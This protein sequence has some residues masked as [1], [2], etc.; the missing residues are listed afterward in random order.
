M[1]AALAPWRVAAFTASFAGLVALLASAAGVAAVLAG[2]LAFTYVACDLLDGAEETAGG[3]PAYWLQRSR[4]PWL[5]GAR[6]V[7]P[8]SRV[9][10]DDEAALKAVGRVVFGAFPHGVLSLHHAQLC[11]DA[12][13]FT[14]SFPNLCMDRRRDLVASVTLRVP[15]YR[16]VLLAMGCVDASRHVAQAVLDSGRSLYVL[17]GG[18]QEQLLTSRGRHRVYVRKR[19]GFVRLAVKNGVPLV[20]VYCF[21]ETSLFYT[22]DFARGLRRWLSSTLQIAVPLACGR[23]GTPVPLPVPLHTVVGAP[24]EVQHEDPPAPA[25]VDR[26]HAEFV[27]RL[28][29][30]FDAHKEACG[31]PDAVLELS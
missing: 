2:V 28:E 30:L 16:D 31:Y 29:A 12:H 23:W 5:F 7:C 11:C 4:V 18:E 24:M 8:N 26:V 6:G 15:L 9:V 3:R 19:K 20:P 21:G 13:G 17:P 27:S 22:S 1:A 25:T 10:V 14:S